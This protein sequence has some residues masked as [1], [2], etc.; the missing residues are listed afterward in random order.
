[1]QPYANNLK[2]MGM[3]LTNQRNEVSLSSRATFNF[4]SN[5]KLTYITN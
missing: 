2:V 5:L 4:N 3:N 1:M